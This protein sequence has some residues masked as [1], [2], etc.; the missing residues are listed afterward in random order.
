MKRPLIFL[1]VSLVIL[2]FTTATVYL[3][4]SS[5]SVNGGAATLSSVTTGVYTPVGAVLY[6]WYGF[7]SNHTGGLGSPGWNSSSCPGGGAVVD[8][9]NLGYYVSDSNQTF[10]TQIAEMQSAGISFAIVSW[11]GPFAQ[12]EGGAINKATQDLFSYLKS[13]NSA[14]KVAIMV[15]AF[16]GMCS[17]SLPDLQ[18][19][20]VYSYVQDRFVAPYSQWYFDWE[21]KPLILFFN[22][23]QPGTNSNFT[24]RTIGNRPN[25]VD[26]TWWDAPSAYFGDQAGNV[27]ATND[28]GPPVISADGEVTLVTRI[29]SYFDRGFQGGS[30][31]RFDANLS[32][33]LYQE[34]WNHVLGHRTSIHLIIIY[35]FNEYHERT[36]IEPHIDENRTLAPNYLLNMTAGYISMLESGSS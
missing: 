2:L 25:Q 14:F 1:F 11:W 26:W 21:G 35:S 20:Q 13:T 22:P 24:V 4:W 28:E 27:N 9:P 33:G 16:P 23:L 30:Y 7:S 32:E 10:E 31:L 19:P 5:R 12:G 18:M 29:D 34:Q 6:L 15:D 17:P 36:A 8:K 3:A